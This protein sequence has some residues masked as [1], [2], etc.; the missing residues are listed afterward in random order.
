M[1][2]IIPAVGIALLLAAAPAAAQDWE[3]MMD[4]AREA[5]EQ[6]H[7]ELEGAMDR[8]AEVEGFPRLASFARRALDALP[9]VEDPREDVHAP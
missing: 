3:A 5:L 4:H 2:S 6:T 8:L 1:R 7:V 9:D